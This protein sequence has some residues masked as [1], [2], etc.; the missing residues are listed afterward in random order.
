MLSEPRDELRVEPIQGQ[1]P[2][3]VIDRHDECLPPRSGQE[4]DATWAWDRADS[5]EPA[6]AAV[7]RRRLWKRR[8]CGSHTA[9]T[10]GTSAH[11]PAHTTVSPTP[12]ASIVQPAS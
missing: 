10:A 7:V 11:S 6:V 3:T 5:A 12:R 8:I 9:A 4:P 1:L 2:A